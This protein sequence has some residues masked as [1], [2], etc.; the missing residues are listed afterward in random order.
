MTRADP[1]KEEEVN[2]QTRNNVCGIVMPISRM[3]EEYSVAHWTRVRKII[4]SAIKRAE[5]TPQVVW[6]NPEIDI[7]Q[8]KILQNIYE[9]DIVICDLSNLNPNVML[10]T[11][12][13]L[14][15]K[16][17]TILITDDGEKRPPF[18]ISSIEYL[19]YPKNLEYNEI[20]KFIGELSTKIISVSESFQRGTYKSF[21]DNY[22]FEVV[23]PSTI[24]VSGEKYI[25][26]QIEELKYMI[27]RISTHQIN[28][29]NN[30]LSN[31]NEEIYQ[32]SFS[33]IFHGSAE[34]LD[35]IF[36]IHKKRGLFLNEIELFGNNE[37]TGTAYIKSD[38]LINIDR[39]ILHLEREGFIFD[40][41]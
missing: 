18:D 30:G 14:S 4:E 21:V 39:T 29:I 40:F 12:L 11:G 10:E 24:Q 23:N 41:G 5:F 27:N 34:D 37:I 32:R 17:P 19:S 31:S 16:R 36:K 25:K 1:P 26:S 8:S 13:R 7:I 38:K 35:E 15:T 6:S 20:E 22:K 33:F 3:S 9:N 28:T 2:P